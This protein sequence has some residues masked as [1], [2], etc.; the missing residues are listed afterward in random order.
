MSNWAIRV[1]YILRHVLNMK[2]LFITSISS[3]FLYVLI[4]SGKVIWKLQFE[5]IVPREGRVPKNVNI[6]DNL[7]QISKWRKWDNQGLR[8]NYSKYWDN[9]IFLLSFQRCWK[10]T[11]S[12]SYAS[13]LLANVR[14]RNKI[15]KH[16]MNRGL[17]I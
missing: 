14:F 8:V 3:V 4:G 5:R 7:R 16:H 17:K 10:K 6:S 11:F 2:T 15:R 13:A 9:A 12:I 1:Y